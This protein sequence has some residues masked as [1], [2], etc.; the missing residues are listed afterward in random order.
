[1]TIRPID[2]PG[3]PAGIEVR[4]S[5]RRKKSVAAHREA[6]MTIVV[7]PER[8]PVKQA[9]AHAVA[10]HQRLLKRAARTRVSDAQ[11]LTRANELRAQYL[12][13]APSPSSISW[14]ANQNRRWGS[15]T[16]TDGSIRISNRL[17]GMPQYVLDYVIMHELTHLL[18]PNHGAQFNALLDNYPQR[19]R[20]CAFLDGA[21]FAIGNW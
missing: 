4:R 11:L 1:M 15:C 6:G 8:M 5:T 2:V 13:N 21:E 7:V 16:T 14:S 20:A 19:S 17:Q 18:V 12:P 10:L 3:L 9:A